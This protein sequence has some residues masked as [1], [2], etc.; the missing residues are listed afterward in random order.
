MSSKL[1]KP[2]LLAVLLGSII[3][4]VWFSLQL[5]QV[6][7]FQVDECE[8]VYAAKILEQHQQEKFYT[9]LSL[10]EVPLIWLARGATRS[11]D[12]FVSARFVMLEIFWLNVVLIVAA[13]G[14]RLTSMRGLFALCA[15]ATL[16]PL[17]DYGF[18]IRHDNLLLTGLLL[19]WCLL[20]V[21]SAG[22]RSFMFAGFLAMG[23]QFVSFKA[24]VYTIPIPIG[25]LFFPGPHIRRP[26]WQLALGW[27]AGI[28]AAFIVIRIAY[29]VTGLWDLYLS[30]FR[31]VSSDAT[32]NNRFS[33]ALAL[34]RLPGQMPLLLALVTAG[35][36]SLAVELWRRNREIF[37]W[38]GWLPEALLFTIALGALLINPTPF[39]YNLLNLVPFGFLLAFRYASGLW[40]QIRLSPPLVSVALTV[41]IFAHIVPFGIATHR[42]LAFSNFRQEH[43]MRLAEQLTN[44]TNDPVYDGVGMVPTRPSID[45]RWFLH[46]FNIRSFV[47]GPGPHVRDMLA[48]RPAAVIIPNYRTDWLPAADHDFI[49]SNYVSLADDFWVLGR[50]LPAGGGNFEIIHPGR[51]RIASRDGSDI[52][53]TYPEGLLALTTPEA[54]G[55]FSGS[56]DGQPIPEHPLELPVGIHRIE[57]APD[58]Q[59]AV[60]WV[61]PHLERLHRLPPGD[62]RSLFVNWY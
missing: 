35:I 6:R 54:S 25:I 13:A 27:M 4:L 41:L 23:L 53:G 24:F 12:L 29:G 42:H 49:A 38:D 32:G 48:A 8:Y 39:P 31:R 15:A 51:Y 52:A 33:P 50:E 47:N 9:I 55:R 26:R 40:Q 45:Y 57:C 46:T 58:C 28:I 11:I 16:A 30:D 14:E 36:V 18:E 59:P 61:G 3:F 56:L 10:L 5:A 7:I 62:H 19:T 22:L 37:K 2:I 44:P 20:R 17:W 60:V 1:L 43:L 21:R 34:R